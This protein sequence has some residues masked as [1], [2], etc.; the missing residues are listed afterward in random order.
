MALRVCPDGNDGEVSNGG[1][2]SANGGRARPLRSL[3]STV[4]STEPAAAMPI[5]STGSHERRF[6]ASTVTTTTAITGI[7]MVP[8]RSVNRVT[9]SSLLAVR[10]PTAASST[11]WS[12]PATPSLSTTCS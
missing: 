11:G 1:T 7:P 8:P 9:H 6:T 5:S 10:V 2:A 12:S 3:P 4:M